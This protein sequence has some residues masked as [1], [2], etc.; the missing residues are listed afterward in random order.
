MIAAALAA[1]SL[2]AAPTPQTPLEGWVWVGVDDGVA[3]AVDISRQTPGGPSTYRSALIGALTRADGRD[4]VILENTLDCAGGLS[5]V[6]AAVFYGPGGD[7][8]PSASSSDELQ[9]LVPRDLQMAMT[10]EACA[11]TV[12][13]TR[14]VYRQL[15][16]LLN[17]ARLTANA[18][19]KVAETEDEVLGVN[20]AGVSA[21]TPEVDLLLVNRRPVAGGVSHIVFRQHM[22]CEARSLEPLSVQ[23][24]GVNDA[25]LAVDAPARLSPAMTAAALERLCRRE[26]D[27]DTDVL[28][29]VETAR[30]RR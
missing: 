6:T 18:W 17:V 23:S 22:D 15:N 13:G 7:P 14:D 12:D 8:L 10:K 24:F 5:R 16:S 20:V 11:Y 25:V 29:F 26:P 1:L 4:Y 27:L 3:G 9:G 28:G 19:E 21:W 2:A 30:P